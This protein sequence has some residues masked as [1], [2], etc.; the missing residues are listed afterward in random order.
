M[1][2]NVFKFKRFEVRHEQSSMKVGVDAV[3]LGAWAGKKATKILDVGTGCGVI[4]LILAQRFPKS[5]II[6]IDSDLISIEEASF[7]F[8]NSPW[9]E[10]MTAL[11]QEFP[12]CADVFQESFDLIVSNPPYF[13]SGISN[14]STRRERARHQDSL[15]VFSLLEYSGH[16]LDSNGRLSIIFPMEF[17][18]EVS[19]KANKNGFFIF[20]ECI[21]LNNKNRKPK[22]VMMEFGKRSDIQKENTEY[23]V[24]F[25]DS[26]PTNE[27]RSLCSNFYLKF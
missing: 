3:L 20:R 5:K 19:I 6:G 15:S 14:P 24:L 10:N 26:Q 18:E 17:R 22:R 25:E 2:K 21:I 4:A 11:Q 16:I 7:N 8:R 13:N 12:N 9:S 1:D 23:L 27:Y